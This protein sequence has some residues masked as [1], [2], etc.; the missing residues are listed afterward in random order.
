MIPRHLSRNRRLGHDINYLRSLNIWDNYWNL[1][2]DWNITKKKVKKG[3]HCSFIIPPDWASSSA[4]FRNFLRILLTPLPTVCFF[5]NHSTHMSGP[6]KRKEDM[7]QYMLPRNQFLSK[8]V[9]QNQRKI[10][11]S[12]CTLVPPTWRSY[13]SHYTV[14][15]RSFLFFFNTVDHPHSFFFILQNLNFYTYY[16]TSK[17]PSIP[18]S[19]PHTHKLISLTMPC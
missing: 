19:F 9:F 6:I 7:K 12:L 17:P 13:L 4:I 14:T 11:R 10:G 16:T 18:F 1:K 5:S 2:E 15:K 8:H 3:N